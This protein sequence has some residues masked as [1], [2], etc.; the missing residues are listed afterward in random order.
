MARLGCANIT[1]ALAALYASYLVYVYFIQHQPNAPLLAAIKSKSTPLFQS[2]LSAALSSTQ[3]PLQSLHFGGGRSVPAAIAMHG[4]SDML[5]H[6]HAQGGDVAAA[7]P[8]DGRTPLHVA[9]TFNS[10]AFVTELLAL[11]PATALH[12]RAD[13]SYTPLLY[14]VLFSQ[15]NTTRALLRAGA[16]PNDRLSINARFSACQLAAIYSDA[17]MMDALVEAG[18][19][20]EAGEGYYEDWLRGWQRVQSARE[21]EAGSDG[22]WDGDDIS[23]STAQHWSKTEQRAHSGNAYGALGS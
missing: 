12:E 5:R 1:L 18:G 14:A 13:N 15:H 16:D 11:L 2:A 21:L 19:V 17:A 9:A 22:V 23:R 6:W 10:A 4:T 8:T 7:S 3:L 20:V